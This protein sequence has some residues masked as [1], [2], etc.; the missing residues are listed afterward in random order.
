MDVVTTSSINPFK[1]KGERKKS[2]VY[3]MIMD[4]L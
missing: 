2:R 3:G 4:S 1:K